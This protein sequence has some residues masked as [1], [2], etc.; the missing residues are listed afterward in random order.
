MTIIAPRELGTATLELID[1]TGR[2]MYSTELVITANG[3]HQL[4]LGGFAPG[5][6]ALRMTTASERSTQ[7]LILK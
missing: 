3:T 7:L 6:Y 4:S 2:T 5:T 1:M